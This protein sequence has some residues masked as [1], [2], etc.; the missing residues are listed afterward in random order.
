MEEKLLEIF[1]LADS[2]NEKQDR[3]YAQ[4]NYSARD[5]KTLEISIRFKK[6]FSFIDSCQ[7]QLADK[8]LIKFEYIIELFKRYIGGVSNE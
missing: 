4:I 3:V 2:L 8:C 7:I 5:T 6:N 1:Q